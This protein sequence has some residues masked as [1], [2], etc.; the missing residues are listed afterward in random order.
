MSATSY[1]RFW[2]STCLRPTT[3]RRDTVES[4]PNGKLECLEHGPQEARSV[5]WVTVAI[6]A[7]DH[8]RT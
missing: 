4:A 1:I 5:D 8:V 2:C 6:R 3:H 7:A